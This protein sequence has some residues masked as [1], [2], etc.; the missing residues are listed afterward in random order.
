MP[1]DFHSGFK[2]KICTWKIGSDDCSAFVSALNSYLSPWGDMTDE[3]HVSIWV[4]YF[5]SLCGNYTWMNEIPPF[6]LVLLG[7][8][9]FFPIVLG[10]I[11]GVYRLVHTGEWSEVE[12]PEIERSTA[13]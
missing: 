9:D 8:N 5:F 1:I 6:L 12:R 4:F 13:F 10:L 3:V 11:L 7:S 2:Y